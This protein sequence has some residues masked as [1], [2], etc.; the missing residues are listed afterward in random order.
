L[1]SHTVTPRRGYLR[2]GIYIGCGQM[3]HYAG[4]AYGLRRGQ[5]EKVSFARFARGRAVWGGS[6][7]VA[8]FDRL[9]VIR[10][11]L[12]KVGE[13]WYRLLTTNCDHFCEWCVLGEHRSYQVERR[14]ARPRR[15]VS[16]RGSS[17]R[18]LAFRGRRN[19]STCCWRYC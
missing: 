5:V 18:T 13:D 16:C 12:S 19:H 17:H 6:A 11:A 10:R 4:L 14:L 3:V 9:E 1:G 8:T 2:H 15:K 7:A